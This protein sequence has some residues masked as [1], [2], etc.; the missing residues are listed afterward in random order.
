M[1]PFRHEIF[2]NAIVELIRKRV[3]LVM[4]CSDY[5]NAGYQADRVLKLFQRMG[6]EILREEIG[7][8]DDSR[9]RVDHAFRLLVERLAGSADAIGVVYFAGWWEAWNQIDILLLPKNL[10]RTR[11]DLVPPRRPQF[12][13][14]VD[15]T[16]T[17][18][19]ETGIRARM[20]LNRNYSDRGSICVM[21][22]GSHVFPHRFLFTESLLRHLKTPVAVRHLFAKV[23][24]EVFQHSLGVQRP[25]LFSTGDA[26][27]VH[28]FACQSLAASSML[29]PNF[30]TNCLLQPL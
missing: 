7:S 25:W 23:C 8:K 28:I 24:G 20:C 2:S 9:S 26:D 14:A 19:E 10:R 16:H 11:P 5:L 29:T 4:V 15:G 30:G 6:Y 18:F 22:A 21:Y 3:A 27:T 17:P 12:L 1:N 13:V